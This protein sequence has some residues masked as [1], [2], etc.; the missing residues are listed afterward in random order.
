VSVRHAV[1]DSATHPVYAKVLWSMII[2]GSDVHLCGD[3][4]IDVH[5]KIVNS[6]TKLISDASAGVA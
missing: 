1:G 3:T 4:D 2:G 5:S 6:E